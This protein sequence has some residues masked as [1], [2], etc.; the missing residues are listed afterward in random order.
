MDKSVEAVAP[1][2][3]LRAVSR[4]QWLVFL[5]VWAGWTLDAADFGLFS[6]VLRPPMIDLLGGN[7]S[8]ADIGKYGRPLVAWLLVGAFGG[9]F[10]RVTAFMTCFA[11]LSIIAM[12]LGRETMGDPLPR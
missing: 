2:S 10:D 5:V 9:S 12:L 11:L 1:L 7:P 3:G 4:Y 8:M 6:L